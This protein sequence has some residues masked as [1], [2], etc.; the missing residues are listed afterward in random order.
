MQEELEQYKQKEARKQAE[1]RAKA[2]AKALVD[3]G[4]APR[5]L[6]IIATPNGDFRCVV[7]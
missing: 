3:S 4:L 6:D 1:A 7:L 5:G 2:F